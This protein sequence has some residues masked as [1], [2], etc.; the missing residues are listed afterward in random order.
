MLDRAELRRVAPYLSDSVYG[1][2]L[3]VDEGKLNPLL[4]NQAIRR[5]ALEAGVIHVTETRVVSLARE[6]NAYRVD[7]GHQVIRCGTVVL[8][9]GA[10]TGA[11][12]EG[13]GANV[14]TV[15]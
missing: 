10:G 8:A 3:C 11:L 13:L 4:A 5:S 6:G 12:A 14:P 2:E 9:T 7:T 15:A 1:A